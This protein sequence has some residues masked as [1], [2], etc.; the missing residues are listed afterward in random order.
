MAGVGFEQIS[1][2]HLSEG[3]FPSPLK[4]AVVYLPPT[5]LFVGNIVEKVVA[6][7]LQR[8]LEEADYLDSLQSGFVLVYSTENAFVMLDGLWRYLCQAKPP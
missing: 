2:L 3:I 1:T 5:F 7:Q 4:V 6:L 8:I